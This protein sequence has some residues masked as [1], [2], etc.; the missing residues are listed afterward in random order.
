[1][2]STRLVNRFS[3]LKKQAVF[4]LKLLVVTFVKLGPHFHT[5]DVFLF[6]TC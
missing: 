6:C 4:L 3:R 1:M 5:L 2:R